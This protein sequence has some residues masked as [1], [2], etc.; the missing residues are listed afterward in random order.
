MELVP[1]APDKNSLYVFSL[2]NRLV[3]EV[4]KPTPNSKTDHVST[5]TAQPTSL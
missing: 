5:L 1:S 2:D 3:F 4:S